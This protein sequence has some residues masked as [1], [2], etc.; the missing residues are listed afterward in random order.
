MLSTDIDD[1]IAAEIDSQGP[2]AAIAVTKNGSPVY[3]KGHGLAN[4]EWKMPNGEQLTITAGTLYHLLP[5]NASTFYTVEDEE[6]EI[7][8]EDVDETEQRFQRVL[9]TTPFFS[10]VAARVGDASSE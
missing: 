6:F 10:L 1:L 4:L 8:F 5:I 2:G 3:C 9:L 7:C